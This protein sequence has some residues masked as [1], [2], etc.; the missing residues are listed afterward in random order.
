LYAFGGDYAPSFMKANR[1]AQ[2]AHRRALGERRPLS[3]TKAQQPAMS[4]PRA[5]STNS[6]KDNSVAIPQVIMGDLRKP[7]ATPPEVSEANPKLEAALDRLLQGIRQ[8]RGG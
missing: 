2:E 5:S 3:P 8:S 6:P 4:L 7:V 1:R